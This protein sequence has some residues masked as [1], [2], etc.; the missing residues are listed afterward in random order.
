M[1]NS[2]IHTYL[3]ETDKNCTI[4]AEI[5]IAHVIFSCIKENSQCMPSFE[6]MAEFIAFSLC[7]ERKW[8]NTQVFHYK[9]HWDITWYTYPEDGSIEPEIIEYWRKRISEVSNPVMK[10][11]YTDLVYEFTKNQKSNDKFTLANSV[12]ETTIQLI[13]TSQVCDL[14]WQDYLQR[15]IT[16]VKSFRNNLPINMITL[17][18]V[19]ADFEER[20]AIDDEKTGLWWYSFRLFVLDLEGYS[21]TNDFKDRLIKDIHIRMER[22]MKSESIDPW[23]VHQAVSLLLEYY[24]KM[25]NRE[26]VKTLLLDLEQAFKSQSSAILSTYNL[27]M[28]HSLYQDHM[29]FIDKAHL[30]RIETEI[31]KAWWEVSWEMH[32]IETTQE[33][34]EEE[35]TKY[36]HSVFWEPWSKKSLSE[37]IKAIF[38]NFILRKDNVISSLKHTT[39][40]CPFLSILS[41]NLSN[42]QGIPTTIVWW[43]L[44]NDIERKIQHHWADILQYDI[45]IFL[46]IILEEFFKRFDVNE[47]VGEIQKSPIFLSEDT[48]HLKRILSSYKE[49]DY[50]VTCSLS[51]PYIESLV[52]E[53][54]SYMKVP[55]LKDNKE[56]WFDYTWLGTLL[57]T[58]NKDTDSI[59]HKFKTIYWSYG[60]DVI[61][62]LDL[63][64]TNN[65]WFNLRNDFCHW[66][67]RHIFYK[68]DTADMLLFVLVVFAN[69][70]EA[71]TP[72]GI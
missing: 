40:S 45:V 32:M 4:I 38:E 1:L 70:L 12:V 71:P 44:S 50:I 42:W 25:K 8:T 54:L 20:T 29:E 13:E 41:C 31:Q 68:K 51:I 9:S 60:E 26:A 28:I 72:E 67:H 11:R 17:A 62:H 24:K 30:S 21:I 47:M 43:V 66:I 49:W 15:A 35:I 34:P 19:M 22:L 5:D 23:A 33:I 53:T 6:D 36:M 10:L 56:W 27:T 7:G 39:E 46:W 48:N 37:V 18:N 57:D 63:V 14:L 61:F 69:I 16:M 58:K 64:L 3:N 65:L 59:F 52:R 55:V 2:T